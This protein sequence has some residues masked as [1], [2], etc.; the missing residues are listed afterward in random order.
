MEKQNCYN[1]IRKTECY[2]ALGL[3]KLEQDKS[4]GI[5]ENGECGA[6]FIN[7]DEAREFIY[8][9]GDAIYEQGNEVFEGVI[10]HL[11]NKYNVEKCDVAV[12]LDRYAR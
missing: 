1:C 9:I 8:A 10:S 11:A 3:Q 2:T 4:F 12:E 7:F 6:I 5:T